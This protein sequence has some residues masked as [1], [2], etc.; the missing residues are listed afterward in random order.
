MQSWRPVK[1]LLIE[2]DDESNA[3][4]EQGNAIYSAIEERIKEFDE[5]DAGS[6]NFRY[7]VDRKNQNPI[8][9]ALPDAKELRRLKEIIGVIASYFGSFD[10]W[11]HE[12][13]NSIMEAW[14]EYRNQ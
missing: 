12:Q 8:L 5:I 9:S 11:V 3:A 13:R 6:F 10:T 4:F 1:E 2:L 7:P 14:H